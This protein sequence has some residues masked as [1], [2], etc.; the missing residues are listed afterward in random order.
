VH[1][2]AGAIILLIIASF[3]VFVFLNVNEMRESA[4]ETLPSEWKISA[5]DSSIIHQKYRKNLIVKE[6]RRS[7]VRESVALLSYADKYQVVLYKIPVEKNISLIQSIEVQ[8][9]SSGPTYGYTYAILNYGAYEFKYKMGAINAIAKIV[10]LVSG[11]SIV[12]QI[13]NDSIVSYSLLCNNLSLRYGSA[14]PVDIFKK[15]SET[16]FG[17]V[18]YIPMNIAFVKRDKFIYFLVLS[19]KNIQEPLPGSF[20]YNIITGTADE[21]KN[22]I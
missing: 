12:K 11:D 5:A 3:I 10:L 17:K 21:L 6:V 13:G 4:K 9:Q 15:A 19:P 20:L 7:K 18:K 14:E 8:E 16:A 2:L 1:I 22:L